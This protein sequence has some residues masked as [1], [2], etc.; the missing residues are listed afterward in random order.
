[1]LEN[2]NH[3][4]IVLKDTSFQNIQYFKKNVMNSS[5]F[6]FHLGTDIVFEE[7]TSVNN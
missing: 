2:E 7:E 1:M 4:A 6:E 5:F 3:I